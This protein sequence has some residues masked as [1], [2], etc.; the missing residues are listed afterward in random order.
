M[1]PRCGEQVQGH[2]DPL[3]LGGDPPTIVAKLLAKDEF[4]AH[5][6][7]E[8]EIEIV[9]LE[10]VL[11]KVTADAQGK[12]GAYDLYY[13]DQSWTSLFAGDTVDPREHYDRKRDL[14]LPDFDWNDFSKPLVQGIST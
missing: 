2:D 10:Q 9:P 3:R 7:I 5:T 13:M 8:V 4:T 6:G 12:L 1:A 14:A 11:Q